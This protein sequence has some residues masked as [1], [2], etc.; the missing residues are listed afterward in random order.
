MALAGCTAMAMML[1]PDE[2]AVQNL[3]LAY[4]RWPLALQGHG[5]VRR[6]LAQFRQWLPTVRDNPRWTIKYL[7]MAYVRLIRL[8]RTR[9]DRRFVN[10]VRYATVFSERSVAAP[11]F[12]ESAL[13]MLEQHRMGLDDDRA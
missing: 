4:G 11:A 10:A 7:S 8:C 9:R 1:D 6:V 3:F 13:Q 5:A 2:H 12:A